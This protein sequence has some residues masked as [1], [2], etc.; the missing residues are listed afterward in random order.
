[1]PFMVIYRTTDGGSSYEQADAI[2]EAA[3]LVERL[4]NKDGLDEIP[5][6]EP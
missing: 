2:D 6:S 1:M 3:L 4:R 5:S